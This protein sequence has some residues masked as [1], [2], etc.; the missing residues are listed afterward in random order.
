MSCLS[1]MN[2]SL[3]QKVF[4]TF[5]S[6]KIDWLIALFDIF[7]DQNDRFSEPFIYSSTRKSLPLNFNTLSQKNISVSGGAYPFR[8]LHGVHFLSPFQETGNSVSC[9]TK[10]RR[11]FS[12]WKW[13]CQILKISVSLIDKNLPWSVLLLTIEMTSKCGTTSRRLQKKKFGLVQK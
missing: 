9:V 11:S 2:K 3:K 8:P 4:S 12:D 5:H 13:W 7:P 10:R 1:Y 6:H